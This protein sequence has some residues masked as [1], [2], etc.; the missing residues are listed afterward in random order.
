MVPYY[1]KQAAFTTALVMT[2]DTEI[3]AAKW[4]RVMGGSDCSATLAQSGSGITST[5][6]LAA[7]YTKAINTFKN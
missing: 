7:S 4:N 6:C 2:G 5:T 1:V 3:T